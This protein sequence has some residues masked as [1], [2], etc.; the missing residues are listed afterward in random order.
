MTV[1]HII[2]QTFVSRPGQECF[3]HLETSPLLVKGCKLWSLIGNH[4]WSLSSEGS[5]AC[6]TYCDTRHPFIMVIS[7]EPLQSHLKPSL[8]VFTMSVVAGI[9]TSNF[10]LAG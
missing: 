8:S 2:I 4:G 9:R 10:P 7:E 3:T 1:S 6:H 5:L